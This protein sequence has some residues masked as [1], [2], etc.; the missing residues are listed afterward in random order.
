MLAQ[1]KLSSSNIILQLVSINRKST[2]LLA[3]RSQQVD[4]LWLQG[5]QHNVHQAAIMEGREYSNVFHKRQQSALR[6]CRVSLLGDIQRMSGHGP[7]QSV[8]G[9]PA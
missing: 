5:L 4:E 2:I 9:D 3:T 8:W 1:G 6:G 7:R